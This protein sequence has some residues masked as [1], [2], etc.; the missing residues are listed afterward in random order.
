MR[1]PCSYLSVLVAGLAYGTSAPSQECASS[2]R[3]GLRRACVDS[4]SGTVYF[5]PRPQP[6]NP[7][8]EESPPLVVGTLACGL[9]YVTHGVLVRSS[10]VQS[11]FRILQ[12]QLDELGGRMRCGLRRFLTAFGPQL[13]NPG[14]ARAPDLNGMA[15][16][17]FFPIGL[18][19]TIA[20]RVLMRLRG[21]AR[22]VRCQADDRHSCSQGILHSAAT[23]SVG[24]PQPKMQHPKL[25]DNTNILNCEVHR[26]DVDD[27]LLP[28]TIEEK[29]PQFTAESPKKRRTSEIEAMYS[30]LTAEFHQMSSPCVDRRRPELS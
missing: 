15:I 11:E 18:M 1:T 19:A 4:V 7:E 14:D 17:R 20:L 24:V 9:T 25:D 13:L 27:V 10:L 5:E 26:M 16:A 29:C 28:I 23:T 6:R 12:Q 8:Q 3:A 30:S 21:I 2:E 22:N